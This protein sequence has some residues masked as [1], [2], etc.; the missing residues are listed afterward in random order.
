[1]A[2]HVTSA[3]FV[4]NL[5]EACV[6]GFIWV[7]VSALAY[8]TLG[9]NG[10]RYSTAAGYMAKV[11]LLILAGYALVG[12]MTGI[13][14]LTRLDNVA[15][16]IGCDLE[17]IV[18]AIEAFHGAIDVDIPDMVNNFAIRDIQ[19]LSLVPIV[20]L[21]SVYHSYWFAVSL[22]VMIGQVLWSMLMISGPGYLAI[23]AF[24]TD[25]VVM[26]SIISLIGVICH[27]LAH[28][29]YSA[30][31]WTLKHFAVW[32]PAILYFLFRTAFGVTFILSNP[33][34]SSIPLSATEWVYPGLFTLEVV[35]NVILI[36]LTIKTRMPARGHSF[37]RIF[38]GTLAH[39]N[40]E[41]E[42]KLGKNRI[43]NM[44]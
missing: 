28:I 36:Y 7:V 24:R 34:T 37:N 41:E 3:M 39:W 8:F 40:T 1:M 4:A 22:P 15:T 25:H 33:V 17:P 2:V 10:N 31:D 29:G 21:L 26:F 30:V 23:R 14:M 35:L 42:T 18:K 5:L 20:A 16:I 44:D 38:F 12:S 32:G 13:L 19:V 43:D 9:P 11:M 27:L 6:L